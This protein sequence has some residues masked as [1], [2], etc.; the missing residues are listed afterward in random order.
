LVL[1]EL[2]DDEFAVRERATRELQEHGEPARAQLVKVLEGQPTPEVKSRVQRALKEIAKGPPRIV[3]ITLWLASNDEQAD[4][5][6]RLLAEGQPD[7]WAT[8][9]AKDILARREK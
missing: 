2:D 9:E 1:A 7:S 6:L 3:E 5:L 8:K 4:A